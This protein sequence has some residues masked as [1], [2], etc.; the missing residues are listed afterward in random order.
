MAQDGRYDVYGSGRRTMSS[1]R[2]EA[3]SVAQLPDD[4]FVI[5][6]VSDA[7]AVAAAMAGMDAVLHIAAVPDPRNSFE[8]VLSSNIV[9][10]HNVL[11]ACRQ[12]GIKRLVYAS[13]IMV[14]WGYFTYEDPYLAIRSNVSMTYPT[15]TIVLTHL[16]PHAPDR[17]LFGQQSLGRGLLPQLFRRPWHLHRLPAHRLGQQGELLLHSRRTTR[18]G[19]ATKIS[20]HLPTRA[21]RHR[22]AALRHLLC[23]VRQSLS[24]GGPGERSAGVGLCAQGGA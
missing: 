16:D 7:D 1:A 11:E 10:T 4:H 19:A 9:G 13:S 24:M 12:A 3:S 2:A 21:G 18:S 8:E 14:N 20:Q 17:T 5:A 15:T 23:G 6:D 22:D